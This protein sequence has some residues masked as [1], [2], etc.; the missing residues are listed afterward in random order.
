MGL[1]VADEVYEIASG[2]NSLSVFLAAELRPQCRRNWKRY[3]YGLKRVMGQAGG[4]FFPN[5]PE[6][7]DG[8]RFSWIIATRYTSL[9]SAIR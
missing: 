6:N 4:Y 2:S 8:W 3:P 9:G 5:N 7:R 1:A